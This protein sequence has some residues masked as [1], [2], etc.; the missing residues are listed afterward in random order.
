MKV[1]MLRMFSAVV[2]ISVFALTPSLTLA[3]QDDK[4]KVKPTKKATKENSGRQA[5][6]LPSGL[7]KHTEKKGQLPSGLQKMKD[8][9]GQLTKGLENGGKTLSSTKGNKL[10]K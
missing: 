2:L 9:D 3:K 8:Q 1:S 5:G 10:V 4:P 7:E 6:E